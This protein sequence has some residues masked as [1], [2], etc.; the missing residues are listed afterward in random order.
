[1]KKVLLINLYAIFGYFAT[2]AII[3]LGVVYSPWYLFLISLPV[4]FGWIPFAEISRKIENEKQLELCSVVVVI[5]FLLS[6]F[7]ALLCAKF[8]QGDLFLEILLCVG[9]SLTVISSTILMIK[10][11]NHWFDKV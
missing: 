7:A 5:D 9:L 3:A 6:I 10:F 11:R 2:G 4:S 1:M 8:L